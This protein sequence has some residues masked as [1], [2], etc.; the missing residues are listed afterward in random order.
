MSLTVSRGTE[1]IR[2]PVCNQDMGAL[3]DHG[4]YDTIFFEDICEH[5]KAKL[6]VETVAVLVVSTSR[7]ETEQ[8]A[9]RRREGTKA[10]RRSTETCIEMAPN[11][12]DRHIAA[13]IR[14]GE[15]VPDRQELIDFLIKSVKARD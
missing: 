7:Q 2:C 10:D 13:C 8:E 5:C 3:G 12:A 14:R 11:F 6:F 4:Q 15:P 1:H 9:N